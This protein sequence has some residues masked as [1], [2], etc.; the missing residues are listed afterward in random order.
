MLAEDER[1]PGGGVERWLTV[2]LAGA[3]C[4]FGCVFCDLW[5]HT[6]RGRTPVG[7]LPAQVAEACRRPEAEGCTGIKLYN[8]SN[9]F[10][11]RAVPPEDDGP[12]AEALSPFRRVLA[13]CHPR[14]VGER[15][16]AFADRLRLAGTRLEVAMGLETVHPDALPR[17]GKGMDLSDFDRACG[18]LLDAGCGLR[19]FVLVGAPFVPA[20]ESVEWAV[21]S[22]AHAFAR[23]VGH[24]S[25]I[26]VRGGTPELAALAAAGQWTPPPLAH[27][28]AALDRALPLAQARNAVVV[29]DL[30]DLDR[31]TRCPTCAPA[32]RSRLAR[33]NR[34]GRP[35]PPVSCPDCLGGTAADPPAVGLR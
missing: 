19:A 18:E 14:L 33:I 34:T 4:P 24:V 21:R 7:A 9:L 23:G 25:L 12:L 3:E 8:A 32:R 17:L 6:L 22:A 26:P 13:E 2:F 30:W 35:R 29:A 5:R 31:F 16:F 28:E 27:L 1:V 11:P 15:C 10:E 20:E